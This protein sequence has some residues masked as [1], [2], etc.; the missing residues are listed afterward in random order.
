M[1]IPEIL[2]SLALV[3]GGLLVTAIVAAALL[4]NI[5]PKN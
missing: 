1:S 3:W 5:P 4:K 2:G